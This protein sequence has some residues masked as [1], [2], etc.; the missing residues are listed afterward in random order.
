VLALAYLRIGDVQG[1]PMFANLGPTSAALASSAQPLALL[2]EASK[3]RPES[4]SVA[5]D[6]IVA[7][8]RRADL[9]GITLGR[10]HEALEEMER[11]RQ[12]TLAELSRH[13]D[14]LVFQGDL[15][16]TYA[17]LIILKNAAGDTL[18]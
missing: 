18:G 10:T 14:N 5:H 6:L 13:P 2:T 16:V 9:L 12:R 15:G 4:T 17:R 8:Q 7:S 1:R 3:S 11:I